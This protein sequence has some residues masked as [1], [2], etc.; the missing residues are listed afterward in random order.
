MKVVYQ[1]TVEIDDEEVA[2]EALHEQWVQAAF[3]HYWSQLPMNTIRVMHS[4]KVSE[5]DY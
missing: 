3:D 1:I 4:K 2:R 5:H